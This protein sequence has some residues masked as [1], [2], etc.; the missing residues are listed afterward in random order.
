M[1]PFAVVAGALVFLSGCTCSVYPVLTDD[2]L[3]N[4]VDLTGTWRE[5]AQ[6]KPND[7]SQPAVVSLEGYADHTSY[8]L[9]TSDVSADFELQVGRLGEHRILQF[10]RQDSPAGYTSS[11]L[12]GLPVYRMARFELRDDQLL[13]FPVRDEKV[14]ELLRRHKIDHRIHSP[15]PPVEWVVM[16][17]T[18]R[19]LQTLVRDAAPELFRKSP[20]IY[21]RISSEPTPRDSASATPVSLSR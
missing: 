7:R 1:R 8:D 10:V 11:V 20:V 21:R 17:A 16:T 13:V 14:I 3:T 15:A 5:E 2:N 4:D 9:T 18:T 12:T 6:G 19:E